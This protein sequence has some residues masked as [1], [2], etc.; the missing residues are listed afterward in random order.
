[1]VAATWVLLAVP[2]GLIAGRPDLLASALIRDDAPWCA[3]AVFV[4]NGDVD[5]HRTRHGADVF[6]RTGAVWFV[7]SGAGSGGDS[8]ELMAEAAVSFG[9]PRSAI[10]V[11]PLAT[12]TRENAVLTRPLLEARGVR[13]VAVVTDPLHSRRLSMSARRAWPGVRVLSAPVPTWECAPAIWRKE[14]R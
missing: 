12:S 5:F 7:V 4:V 9:V 14:A 1:M 10:V 2:V 3:D 13:S 11:E 6:R 8:G